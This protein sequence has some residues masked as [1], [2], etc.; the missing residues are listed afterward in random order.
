[1]SRVDLF[2]K[3]LLKNLF[4]SIYFVLFVIHAMRFALL[5]AKLI[6]KSKRIENY[7]NIFISGRPIKGLR[8]MR[9]EHGYA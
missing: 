6:K 4:I 7:L 8:N 5:C 1:M 2:P 3:S 9:L